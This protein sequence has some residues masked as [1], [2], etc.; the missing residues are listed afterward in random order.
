M[1]CFS[2]ANYI[3]NFFQSCLCPRIPRG[4]LTIPLDP[5]IGWR[6]KCPLIGRLHLGIPRLLFVQIKHC[7][8]V[9]E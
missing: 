7:E 1:M 6:A 5:L 2:S 4:K 8:Q 9:S 3:T